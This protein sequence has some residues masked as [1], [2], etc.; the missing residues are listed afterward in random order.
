MS[1]FRRYFMR[2]KDIW[3]FQQISLLTPKKICLIKSNITFQRQTVENRTPRLNIP[4]KKQEWGFF[5]QTIVRNSLASEAIRS[6]FTAIEL[7]FILFLSDEHDQRLFYDEKNSTLIEAFSSWLNF[8]YSQQQE[9]YHL[10]SQRR[11]ILSV[12]Q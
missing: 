1:I 10:T 4:Q 2:E 11:V 7:R 6:T 8:I 9:I 5:K 12:N 3:K